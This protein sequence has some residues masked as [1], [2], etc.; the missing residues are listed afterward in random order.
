MA[1]QVKVEVTVTP[2][3]GLIETLDTAGSVLSTDTL[4]V[5]TTLAP[6]ESVAITVQ[7]IVSLGDA[8]ELDRVMLDPEPIVLEELLQT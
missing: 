3:L 4:S 1:E 8:V 2:L 6:S 7:V 5:L